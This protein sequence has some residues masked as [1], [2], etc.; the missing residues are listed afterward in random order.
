M[1]RSIKTYPGPTGALAGDECEWRSS[2]VNSGI[3][4]GRKGLDPAAERQAAYRRARPT[5]GENGERH[6][7]ARVSTGAALALNRLAW[8]Y[9][10]TQRDMLERLIKTADDDIVA[11]LD[12]TAPEWTAYFAMTR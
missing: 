10:V 5:A 9:G 2:D 12:P 8:C 7:S 3:A 1:F 11:T 6:I 4:G